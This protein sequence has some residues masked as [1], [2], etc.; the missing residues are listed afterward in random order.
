MP[1]VVQDQLHNQAM[2]E[3]ACQRFLESG[4]VETLVHPMAG[5]RR[6]KVQCWLDCEFCLCDH[7]R[8]NLTSI[9]L[10]WLCPLGDFGRTFAKR[11]SIVVL[12]VEIVLVV[13]VVLVQRENQ[14][15][16]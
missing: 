3:F 12:C 4:E 15:Q 11:L 1:K 2:N 7:S 13:V 6:L 8:T 10:F 9:A 16:R 14:L 5:K